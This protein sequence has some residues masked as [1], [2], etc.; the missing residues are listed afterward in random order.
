ML[1][2][3]VTAYFSSDL[4]Q[5]SNFL[6]LEVKNAFELHIKGDLSA[7]YEIN[8]N[9]QLNSIKDEKL[10]KLLVADRI[11]LAVKIGLGLPQNIP[12]DIL[13]DRDTRV[14]VAILL[15]FQ[16]PSSHLKAR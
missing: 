10:R 2:P 6:P 11:W 13:K 12:A 7:S 4:S 1:N 8:Q 14:I 3:I 15:A 16:S 9:I 5:V